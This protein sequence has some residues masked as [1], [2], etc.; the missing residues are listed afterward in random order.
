MIK[1]M[2]TYRLIRAQKITNLAGFKGTSI[3]FCCLISRLDTPG[4]QTAGDLHSKHT[5]N[6]VKR[7]K[8]K[9]DHEISNVSGLMLLAECTIDSGKMGDRSTFP[10]DGTNKA[11][12]ALNSSDEKAIKNL[13]FTMLVQ[14]GSVNP[15]PYFMT[16]F[17]YFSKLVL[18]SIPILGV[19][20]S[21]P[22]A[23]TGHITAALFV[24]STSTLLL[25]LNRLAEKSQAFYTRNQMK[26]L[27][28]DVTRTAKKAFES[29]QIAI[30]DDAL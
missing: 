21:V 27:C 16:R 13:K 1:S 26:L 17:E 2:A 10:F 23:I 6:L 8:L 20:A 24:S 18:D 30:E 28:F 5:L 4:C 3:M 19:G 25:F 11:I 22:I 29:L 12:A 15:K 9:L 14:D 7:C